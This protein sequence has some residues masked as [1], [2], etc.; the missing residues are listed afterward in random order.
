MHIIFSG[1]EDKQTNEIIDRLLYYGKEVK[2]YNKNLDEE[3]IKELRDIFKNKEVQ[4]NLESSEKGC[5]LAIYHRRPAL[6]I[7][8]QLINYD[9]TEDDI[10][11]PV[12][13]EG[14]N[15]FKLLKHNYLSHQ[16]KFYNFVLNN[17][18]YTICKID[19]RLNKLDVLKKAKSIGITIPPTLVSG[20]K[21]EVLDFYLKNDRNII[22]KSLFEIIPKMKETERFW[23]KTYT[24]KIE[25][26]DDLPEHFF[27][28]LFQKNI[29]KKYELRIFFLD[30][31]CY[32]AAIL[33]QSDPKSE[34][35]FRN[36]D[37]KNQNR[38]V[39]YK[40]SPK[41][42]SQIIDLMK[43]V[44]LNT[45]SL[46]FMIGKDGKPYFL[47]IN[48]VGQFGFINSHCNFSI[49]DDIAKKMIEFHGNKKS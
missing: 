17:P 40:L 24:Q 11:Y 44:E 33:S 13:Q 12:F 38:V 7:V 15:Y 42:K 5:N 36:Q 1:E 41:L 21:S 26:I 19:Y 32:T 14:S 49:S 35:D 28:T 25:I 23:I 16:A 47:E 43:I 2:R 18:N 8:D 4:L 22:T 46:D 48:P 3:E 37:K 39:P 9:F 34:I 10:S 20:N 30:G 45:G 31:E 6:N 29:E 27:P